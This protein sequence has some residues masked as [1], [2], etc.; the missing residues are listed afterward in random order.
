MCHR[1][2]AETVKES[3]HHAPISVS[4]IPLPSRIS[5]VVVESGVGFLLLLRGLPDL[6]LERG[7]LLHML[8][9]HLFG[10]VETP[11]RWVLG[12]GDGRVSSMGGG[13][14]CFVCV[15]LWVSILLWE[16]RLLK[17][18]FSCFRLNVGCNW[19]GLVAC[20][21]ACSCVLFC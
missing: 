5:L 4:V 7:R 16:D 6:P 2:I 19:R 10:L 18:R 11:S 13:V 14:H 12:C 21:L 1:I 15:H 8:S 9:P 17:P 3:S 20:F